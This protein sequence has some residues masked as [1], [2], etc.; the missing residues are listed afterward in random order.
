MKVSA[1][2]P[3]GAAGLILLLASALAAA[4]A[5]TGRYTSSGGVVKDN[6]T[7]LY[8]QQ[9]AT[10]VMYTFASAM[11]YCSGNIAALPGSGWRLPAVKELETLVDDSVAS[12]GPTIDAGAFPST[13][14]DY[15]WSST[16]AVSPRSSDAWVVSFSDG[17][18]WAVDSSNMGSVRCIR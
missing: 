5:P 10:P 15:F 9:A 16:P 2:Y 17:S 11:T 7:G 4:T 13:P 3:A 8:W 18:A 14:A 1:G 12:P 6:K